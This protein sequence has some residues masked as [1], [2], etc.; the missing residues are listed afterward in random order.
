MITRRCA[1]RQLLMRPDDETNNAFIYCLAEAA[2][3]FEIDVLFTV[4]VAN[5][6]HTGICD[7]YGNYPRFLE[8]FHKLYAKHQNALRGRW[9]NFWSAEQTS[10]VRLVDP[11]DVVRKMVY[12]LTNPVL[13]DLV[14]RAGE[15]PGVSSLASQLRDEPVHAARPKRFFRE[16]GVMPE[17][18]TL[19]FARPAGFEHLSQQEWAARLRTEVEKVERE[20]AERRALH[21]IRVMGREKILRQSPFDYPASAE[22]RREMSPRVAAKNKWSRIEAL[23]RNKTFEQLYAEARALFQKGAA[24]L[25]PAGT[26]WLRIFCG[27]SCS[28]FC[29]PAPA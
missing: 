7:R 14:E 22:P 23:M 25:F 26:W 12:A 20:A 29:D 6:H 27:V 8:H 10:V 24:A 16:D 4:S 17:S 18:A 13:S 2:Q 28:A 3:R 1:Q 9:E 11:E 21:K 15:W 19:R 5:H